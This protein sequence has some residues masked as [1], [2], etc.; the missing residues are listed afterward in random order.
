MSSAAQINAAAPYRARR[1]QLG[2]FTLE[3]A[4]S[5]GSGVTSTPQ[6]YIITFGNRL[7]FDQ[8]S[9]NFGRG[10]EAMVYSAATRFFLQLADFAPLTVQFL[11]SSLCEWCN[12][13]LGKS[14]TKAGNL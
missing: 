1:D 3:I 10:M 9:S 4:A 8:F 14:K 5:A 12:L 13:G 6:L 7:M 2:S 11:K